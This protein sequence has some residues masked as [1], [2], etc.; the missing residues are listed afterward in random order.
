MTSSALLHSFNLSETPNTS[1]EPVEKERAPG[2]FHRSCLPK[3]HHD[4]G[5]NTFR[6]Y[7][8]IRVLKDIAI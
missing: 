6:I 1:P 7:L 8:K 3:K 4:K 2:E 5:V